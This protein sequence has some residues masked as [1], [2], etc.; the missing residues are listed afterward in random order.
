MSVTIPNTAKSVIELLRGN[1]DYV[2]AEQ[3]AL[4]TTLHTRVS[5]SRIGHEWDDAWVANDT[6]RIHP[7]ITIQRNGGFGPDVFVPHTQERLLIRCWAS[8]HHNALELATLV[9]QIMMPIEPGIGGWQSAN[10]QVLS[11]TGMSEPVEYQ[12]PEFEYRRA[13]QMV[14]SMRVLRVARP[15]APEPDIRFNLVLGI[16]FDADVTVGE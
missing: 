9:Q 2:S 3:A 12:D 13:M 7:A 10:T 15:P 5:A 1:A 14:G 4:I 16:G 8:Y 11:V 6:G